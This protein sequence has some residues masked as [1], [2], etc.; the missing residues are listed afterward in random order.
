MY[1][2]RWYQEEAVDSA[3]SWM[4]TST[5]PGLIEAA[6]GAGKSMIIADVARII[7]KISGG[8]SV[9]CLAPS[10]ELVIQN[11]E[12]YLLTGQPASIY[13]ASAGG[14]SVRHPV[15]FGSPL[16]VEKVASK[17]GSRIACILIDEAHGLTPT[18]KNIIELI[19]A[20]NP[21]VRVIGLSATPYRLGEGF[22]Y[23]LDTDGKPVGEECANDPY[24]T[25]CIYRIEARQ[26]I[27]EGFL[28]MPI[29]GE[30]NA[31]A[32][33]TAG[34]ILRKNNTFDS[35]EVDRAFVGQGR[36]TAAIVADIV[37]QARNR[38]G[39]MIFAATI[40]HAQEIMASLPPTMSRMVTG[41]P[42]ITSKQYRKDAINNFKA[43]K[44]KYL[45][46]VAVLTTGFDAPHV[47]LVAILRLTESVGLLQQIIGRGLR[48]Y[49]G[50][51]DCLILDYAGNL[52]RHCPDGDLFKPI[53]KAGRGGGGN[54]SINAFCPDCNTENTFAARKNDDNY[55]IDDHGYFT[56]L[57]GKRIET[58]FGPLPAHHG[59]RCQHLYPVKDG[60]GRFA[61]CGYR[62]TYKDCPSC[63]EPNDIAARYCKSCKGEIIDPNEKLAV[64]FKALK[65]DPKQVQ[66]D[67]VVGFS[68]GPTITGRGKEMIKATFDTE[69]RTFTIW[70]DPSSPVSARQGEYHRYMKATGGGEYAPE[71]VQYVKGPDNFWKVFGYDLPPDELERV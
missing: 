14:K 24:F 9:L 71:T 3:V 30:I 25:K 39:V 20:E 12:K 62:W 67:R 43:Q 65:R 44:F 17:I 33:E 18:I 55:P 53:V 58:D 49:D 63:G 7:T 15:I 69:H 45:V 1:A 4:R 36:K 23:R 70:I 5:E 52:E 21:N 34:I 54:G 48:L 56:D 6:T 37:S 47:D 8:K 60:T 28:T 26:L 38:R 59:R 31:S 35:E 57:D 29:A 66:C 42:K 16:T 27:D 32:Y 22:I 46:N 41:N 50:K 11:R 19:K 10:A 51:A 40:Q 61:Q 64:E 68:A 13:S 2:L